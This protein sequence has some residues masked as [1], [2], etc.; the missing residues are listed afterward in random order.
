MHFIS[1]RFL[2][3]VLLITT[4]TIARSELNRAAF[5]GDVKN[6]RFQN[7]IN[8][9]HHHKEKDDV[10]NN[11]K[12]GG[13]LGP[14]GSF[15]IPGFGKGWGYDGVIGGGYGAGYGSP[16]GG[17]SKGGVIRPVVVCKESGPCYHKKVICPAKCST[18]YR[19]SRSGKH[20][21]A[22]GGSCTI[23]CKKKCTAFC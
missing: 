12:V 23:D 10:K 5:M 7:S 2:I 13:F 11:G 3:A 1:A 22:G 21:G 6:H 4:A 20:Y 9:N 8:N 17:Y 15:G 16:T 18:S 19:G 14:G